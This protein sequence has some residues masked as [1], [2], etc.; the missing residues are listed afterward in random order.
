[1]IEDEQPETVER[2]GDSKFGRSCLVARRLIEAGVSLAMVNWPG[3][4]S[5]FDTHAGHFSSTKN[6]LL[7]LSDQAF[8]ALLEDLAARGMLEETLV[9][10]TSEFGRTPALNGNTPAGRDHWPFVYTNELAGGGFQGGEVY[11]SSDDI[12]AYPKDDPVHARDF[13]ATIYHAL[14][15]DES[16]QVVDHLCRLHSIVAG[17]AV[18]DLF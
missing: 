10:W 8:S 5:H 17:N 13:V 12:T 18:A 6:D 11:G 15:Y 7:P 3:H 1:V 2:Y 9:V 14:G 4:E 16:T